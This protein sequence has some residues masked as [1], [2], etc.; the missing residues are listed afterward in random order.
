MMG[1]LIA[2]HIGQIL[3]L[4]PSPHAKAAFAFSLSNFLL[5]TRLCGLYKTYAI[6]VQTTKAD[7]GGSSSTDKDLKASRPTQAPPR[8][9]IPFLPFSRLAPMLQ[10]VTVHE[11][12]RLT[13]WCCNCARNKGQSGHFWLMLYPPCDSLLGP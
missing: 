5:F 8:V 7:L 10:L 12:I 6:F 4:A 11:P 2:V 9:S 1:T 13:K 3:F